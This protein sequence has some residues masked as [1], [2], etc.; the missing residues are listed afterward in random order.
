M[1]HT[2]PHFGSFIYAMADDELEE[3][4]TTVKRSIILCT[5]KDY[6]FWERMMSLIE[7][8]MERRFVYIFQTVQHGDLF[9]T[10]YGTFYPGWRTMPYDGLKMAGMGL[11]YERYSVLGLN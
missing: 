7:Q 6:E 4:Y 9:R 10:P 2:P 1:N 5:S 11:D 3:Y 8:E